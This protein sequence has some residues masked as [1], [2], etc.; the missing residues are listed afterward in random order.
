ML[1]FLVDKNAIPTFHWIY[2]RHWMYHAFLLVV[3]GKSMEKEKRKHVSAVRKPTQ[4]EKRKQVEEEWG[5]HQ[6]RHSLCLLS[7]YLTCFKE[8]R[9]L[10]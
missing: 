5:V 4:E 9:Y 1:T 6:T 10:V 7:T 2:L 8:D 3:S